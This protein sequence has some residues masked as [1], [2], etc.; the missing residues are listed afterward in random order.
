MN[1]STE[2]KITLSDIESKIRNID[3]QL[4]GTVKQYSDGAAKTGAISIVGIGILIILAYLI[5]RKSGR[6]K[7]TFVEIRRK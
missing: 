5:G 6:L 2:N 3:K 1:E 4:T 7:S